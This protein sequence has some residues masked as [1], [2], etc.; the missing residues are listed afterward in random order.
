MPQKFNA[1]VLNLEKYIIELKEN[2]M[3]LNASFL[4][5]GERKHAI[6]IVDIF[7]NIYKYTSPLLKYKTNTN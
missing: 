4:S 3:F 5:K 6:H 1:L 2:I 7:L